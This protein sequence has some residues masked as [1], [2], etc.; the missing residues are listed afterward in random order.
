M[1]LKKKQCGRI[2]G[3]GWADGRK[4]RLY[5]S[6]EETSAPMVATESLMLSCVIDANKWRT[7]MTAD[8]PGAFMQTDMDKILHMKLEG[9]LAKLLNRVDPKL[10]EKYTTIEKGKPVL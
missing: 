5:K 3:R 2:K 1:F 6:K 9:P 4:Q 10:Y 8:I 7:M